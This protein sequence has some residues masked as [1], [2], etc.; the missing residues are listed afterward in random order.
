LDGVEKLLP[1]LI[2]CQCGGRGAALIPVR[3]RAGLSAYL[4][5]VKESNTCPCVF[6]VSTLSVLVPDTLITE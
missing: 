1:R 6:F 4:V 5:S 3:L 2:S